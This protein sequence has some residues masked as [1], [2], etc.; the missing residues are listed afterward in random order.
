MTRMASRSESKA[1]NVPEMKE[2]LADAAPHVFVNENEQ[3]SPGAMEF[4]YL[5]LTPKQEAC[6]RAVGFSRWYVSSPTDGKR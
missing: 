5:Q 4:A 2:T 3:A 6:R 1:T